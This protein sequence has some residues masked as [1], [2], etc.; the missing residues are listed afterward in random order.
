MADMPFFGSIECT[1]GDKNRQGTPIQ[2]PLQVVRPE[3]EV[4]AAAREARLVVKS[5]SFEIERR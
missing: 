5:R 3:G 2:P 1:F 4:I